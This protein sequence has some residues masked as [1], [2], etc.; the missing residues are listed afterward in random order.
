MQ[1]FVNHL[2]IFQTAVVVISKSCCYKVA[3]G[4]GSDSDQFMRMKVWNTI[5]LKEHINIFLRLLFNL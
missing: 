5:P 2:H 1:S 4:F 3:C